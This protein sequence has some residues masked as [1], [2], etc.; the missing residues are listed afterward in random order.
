MVIWSIVGLLII[1]NLYFLLRYRKYKMINKGRY[2]LPMSSASYLSN[3]LEVNEFGPTFASE[4][5]FIGRGDLIV[6]GGTTDSEAWLLSVLSKEAKTM[7]EFGT[8]TGKTTYLWA[9][10]S[11]EDAKVF[12]LTLPPEGT[13]S[14]EINKEDSQVAVTNAVNESSFTQFL[15]SG[16]EVES[17]VEQ[18]FC[19]S[20][21]FNDNEYEV[22]FDLIFIDGSHAYSYVQNNTEKA[23]RILKK[24]GIIL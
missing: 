19:D 15:Y 6:P 5:S 9:K 8:C 17:K 22:F 7:F 24:N 20:K 23:F 21:N 1:S 4:V 2:Y 10:N 16:T 11:S 13:S 3:L 18:I 14:F 12:T